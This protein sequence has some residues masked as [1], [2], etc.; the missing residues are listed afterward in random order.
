MYRIAT[1]S[2][3]IVITGGGIRDVKLCKKAM[4]WPWQRHFRFEL[5][6]RNYTTHLLAMSQE[7][8]EF[9]L[10]A[11]FTIGPKDEP[12]ALIRYA[13]LLSSK[14]KDQDLEEL[15]KGVI[16]GE[17]RVLAAQMTME[18]IFRES[19]RFK[20]E[21]FTN[22][23]TEL[24]QFGL[25]IYNAN[26]KQLQDAPGS[27]YFTYM[28]MKTHEGAVNQAKV[29]VAQA[30]FLGDVGERER[31]GLTRQ[32]ISKVEADTIVLENQRKA[33][34]AE[35]QA[36]LATKQATY[37]RQTKLAKI[38]S[39]KAAELRDTEL[40]Q[41]VEK[42]RALTETEKLRAS[43][44]AR[45]TADYESSVKKADGKFYERKKE[46][47][48]KLY[49]KEREAEGILKIYEAQ[50]KGVE[51]LISAFNGDMQTF[52]DYLLIDREV[53]VKL[54][55]VNAGAIRG[56]QPKITV[57]N[58]GSSS[59][60]TGAG[61]GDGS[62]GDAMRPIRDIFQTIPPLFATVQEQTGVS[63]FPWM[64]TPSPNNATTPNIVDNANKAA[65][66][67]NFVVTKK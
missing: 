15:I 24:D 61:G 34:I 25:F 43:V 26:I 11:V 46:A 66:T 30:K 59:S 63:P 57:W 44:V 35:A 10:P 7:K 54:A 12:T 65:S 22:I 29:D 19:K 2:Q 40:L 14:V 23:Q 5:G 8:L 38:E 18:E 39:E 53:Y 62:V 27:E 55:E 42:Q 56:L 47:E 48:A 52:R 50:A 13:K 32:K 28:R 4:V 67:S 58:T 31:Q 6:P 21:I 16:E 49:E 20:E 60:S 17:T 3:Y 9:T 36:T 51:R 33:E 37:D 45:A 1:P 41:L 64:V